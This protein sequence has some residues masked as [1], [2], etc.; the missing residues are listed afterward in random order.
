MTQIILVADDKNQITWALEYCQHTWP[1]L[2][3]A[4]DMMSSPKR[5]YLHDAGDTLAS[6]VKS[7]MEAWKDGWLSREVLIEVEQFYRDTRAFLT[8]QLEELS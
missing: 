6:A 4:V 5:I 2:V 7:R 8:K 3:F 1:K